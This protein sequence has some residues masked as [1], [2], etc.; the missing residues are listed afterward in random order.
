MSGSQL[1]TADHMWSHVPGSY[2][3]ICDTHH[4]AYCVIRS[5][6]IYNRTMV[7]GRTKVDG[8][9]IS[10]WRILSKFDQVIENRMRG[11]RSPYRFK[12]D[13]F[14]D[15]IIDIYY[16]DFNNKLSALDT[17]TRQ[18][19]GTLFFNGYWFEI[20]DGDMSDPVYITIRKLA[21]KPWSPMRHPY[22]FGPEVHRIVNCVMIARMLCPFEYLPIEMWFYILSF[23]RR[24]DFRVMIGDRLYVCRQ[25]ALESVLTFLKLVE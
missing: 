7:R 6:N 16:T 12:R 18:L 8:L 13:W 9:T 19:I 10:Q 1:L 3:W 17:E 4:N 21:L 24:T 23:V 11:E 5:V 15:V 22:C 20:M 25:D 2:E 14:T